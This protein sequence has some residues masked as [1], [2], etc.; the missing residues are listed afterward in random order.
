MKVFIGVGSKEEAQFAGAQMVTK[1]QALADRLRDHPSNVAA[2]FF[3][4]QDENHGTS[5]PAIYARGLQFVLP[6]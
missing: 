2:G 1:A 4:V 3:E 6:K 5:A